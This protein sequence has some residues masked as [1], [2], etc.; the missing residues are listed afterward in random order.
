[1]SK[2]DEVTR[3]D[4]IVAKLELVIQM[5]P[6]PSHRYYAISVLGEIEPFVAARDRHLTTAQRV[7]LVYELSRAAN[8]LEELPVAY[9][10]QSGSGMVKDRVQKAKDQ[11]AY[12]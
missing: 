4:D 12:S 3:F 9:R 8:V 2:L 10:V 1:V 11:L 7:R 6:D 5:L